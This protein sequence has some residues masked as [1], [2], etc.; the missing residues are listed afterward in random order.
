MTTFKA[1]LDSQD[2]IPSRHL[3]LTRAMFADTWQEKPAED[4]AIG[5]RKLNDAD[6]Q[7]ARAEAAKYAI[8][9]HNDRE[10]QIDA[11]NDMLM[12][13]MIIAG[14]CD[15]NDVSRPAPIF[16][17]SEENVRS[18]LTSQSIRYIW[19]QLDA[20]LIESSPLVLTASDEE[21]VTLA[22]RLSQGPLPE[23]MSKSDTLRVRKL[24][25][26]VLREIQKHEGVQ[27]DEVPEE[28]EEE[29]LTSE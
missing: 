23:T 16:D 18:A 21:V 9:M 5:L 24:L 7:T 1:L 25:G 8:E 14:T 28:L 27:E 2:R 6:V 15:A 4:L 20:F 26:F 12:R 11:F 17:G 3:V 22:D 29:G 13:W 10:G 19:D